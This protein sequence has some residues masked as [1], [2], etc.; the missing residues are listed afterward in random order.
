MTRKIIIFISMLAMLMIA[1]PAMAVSPEGEQYI[2]QIVGGGSASLRR[3]SQGIYRDELTE[4]LVLDVLS[5]K[6][7]RTYNKKS[8]TDIDALSWA[9][10]AVGQS[11]DIR[12]KNVLKTVSVNTKNAKVRKY[13]NQSLKKM[14]AGKA[15]KPY[16]KGSIDLAKMRKRL[17]N[18]QSAIT[19]KRKSK[20]KKK[21]KH[22]GK[23]SLLSIQNGMGLQEVES[24]AGSPTSTTSHVTGKSFNPYY[25]G[26]DNVRLIHLYKG[27]GRVLYSRGS[28]YSNR[29]WRVVEVQIDLGEPGYP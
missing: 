12:Y 24:I 25:R 16:K 15:K 18:G 1:V 23:N 7:L 27:R 17:E 19:G 6:L 29:R 21:K 11:G 4:R 14:P 2:N 5:E 3:A 26:K 22:K 9:C 20:G 28:R 13:A 10:K 8:K